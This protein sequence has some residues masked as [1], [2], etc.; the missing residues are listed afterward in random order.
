VHPGKIFRT[1]SFRLTLLYAG[2]FAASVTVLFA[3]IYW[4]IAATMAQQL[5]TAVEAEVAVLADEFR[6]GGPASV[7]AAIR[8]RST[9]PKRAGTFYLFQ[10]QHALRLAGDLPPRQ[11]RDGWHEMATPAGSHDAEG[12]HGDEAPIRAKVIRLQG[13]YLLAVGQSTDR[14]QETREIVIGAFGWAFGVTLVLALVG[15]AVISAAFLRR[16]ETIERTSRQIMDGELNLRLPRRGTGDELDRLADGVNRM[17][18]R[19]QELMGGL[20]QVGNDIA[21]DLRTPLSRLRQRLESARSTA[22]SVPDYEAAVEE[23]IAEADRMIDTFS[24]LLRIA[25]I[26][27]RSR[28]SGFAELDLSQVFADVGEIYAPVAED[29]AQSL[30]VAV[31]P[32]IRILGDRDLLTQMLVNLVENALRHSQTGARIELR[33]ERGPD[34]VVGTVADNGPGVPE[35]EHAKVFQR[36]YRLD[37]SRSTPGSGLGLSLVAAVADLHGVAVELRDNH[38]GLLVRL[39]F[40]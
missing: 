34:G 4:T 16:V 9:L 36:F 10:D 26:E 33:L 11:W 19:I 13:G 20:R 29:R 15:G 1:A 35:S 8:R 27:S 2:L 3:I 21:H 28:R 40:P 23:A 22:K 32:G 31:Q 39:K 14:L 24:S 5:D 30:H 6:R 18:D 38:P 7:T 12:E 17:L 25:Q 37:T